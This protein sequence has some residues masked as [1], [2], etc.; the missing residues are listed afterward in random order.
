MIRNH[1]SHNRFYPPL[2]DILNSI[3]RYDISFIPKN[4][5]IT[6]R[7]RRM[8]TRLIPNVTLADH[9]MTGSVAKTQ[10]TP[11]PGE[12]IKLHIPELMTKI[13]PGEAQL[14]TL[15]VKGKTIFINDSSC[16]PTTKQV[17]KEQN[18]LT[19]T[20]GKNT[21][22]DGIDHITKSG[23]MIVKR[24]LP[25]GLQLQCNFLSGI[26]TH[27]MVETN[28]DLTDYDDT[29]GANTSTIYSGDIGH[30]HVSDPDDIAI[31]SNHVD[32]LITKLQSNKILGEK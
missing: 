1:L 17:L 5:S 27:G 19:V 15:N 4:N 31:L 8:L 11:R 22:W 16:K 14:K 9:L 7:G 2:I 18:Y 29:V 25:Y 3:P 30:V 26:L 24:E 21:N 10:T 28:R 32:D 12:S 20:C 23:G 13:D 6:E